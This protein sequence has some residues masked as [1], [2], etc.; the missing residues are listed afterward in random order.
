MT[1]LVLMKI[2]P[3]ACIEP[4]VEG[5]PV[6]FVERFRPDNLDDCPEVARGLDGREAGL[7]SKM[8]AP[9]VQIQ[10]HHNP[11]HPR[12]KTQ[13]YLRQRGGGVDEGEPGVGV[14]AGLL[15]PKSICS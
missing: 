10:R 9:W 13:F 4:K 6:R 1:I 8:G 2:S 15:P 11:P 12:F 5:R 3:K 14:P 7:L